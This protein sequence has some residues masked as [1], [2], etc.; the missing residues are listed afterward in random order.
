MFLQT[1]DIKDE[2]IKLDSSVI[3]AELLSIESEESNLQDKT[4]IFH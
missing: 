2:D 1:E 4:A 3:T